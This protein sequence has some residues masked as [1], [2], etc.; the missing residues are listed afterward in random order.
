M[1][2]EHNPI[3]YITRLNW[4]RWYDLNPFRFPKKRKNDKKK[5]NTKGCV[6]PSPKYD[7]SNEYYPEDFGRP[8]T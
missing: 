7:G 5:Y 8:I 6:D 2:H 1:K 4:S 3:L